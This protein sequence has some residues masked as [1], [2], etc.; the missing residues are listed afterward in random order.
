M[1]V[2]IQIDLDDWMGEEYWG[3]EEINDMIKKEIK[4]SIMYKVKRSPEYKKFIEEKAG[5]ALLTL[6]KELE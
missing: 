5:L 4:E 6:A 3:D 1:K 2:N